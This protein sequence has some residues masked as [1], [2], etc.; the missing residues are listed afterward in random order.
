[1]TIHWRHLIEYCAKKTRN[2]HDNSAWPDAAGQEV[3]VA[4]LVDLHHPSDDAV[5]VLE[6]AKREVA[7]DHFL[8][9][10]K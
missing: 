9:V 6:G 1:M 4:V 2:A 8:S 5:V 7:A 10:G 3:A